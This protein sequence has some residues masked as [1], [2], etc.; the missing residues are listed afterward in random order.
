M[1]NIPKEKSKSLTILVTG[2]GGDI[3]QSVIKCLRDS[4]YELYLIG[5]DIDSYAG[6]QQDVDVFY[7]APYASQTKEYLN[8]ITNVIKKKKCEYIIPTTEQ[9]IEFYDANRTY[10][11]INEI[12]VLINNPFIINIFS[13]KF[14]TVCFLKRHD[15]LYPETYKLSE[16]NNEL[17][18]PVII[19][20]EI[21]SGGK[22][23]HICHNDDELIYFKNMC[24][25]DEIVQEII[26]NPDEEYTIGIFS[27][28]FSVYCI[29]FRRYLD[30]GGRTKVAELIKDDKIDL[31]ARN[32]ARAC[33]LIGSINL[34]VRKTENGFVTFEINPRLSSTVYFRHFFGFRDVEWWLNIYEGYPTEFIPKYNKGIAVRTFDEIFIGLE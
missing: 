14:R 23:I 22:G 29:A 24:N 25:D 17:E 2:I 1:I 8:F 9:E 28:G 11:E 27:D 12:K 32:L 15:F 19:K 31:L 3:G 20:K 7:Q 34:Q 33:K 30:Y 21:G 5:C 18:F 13:N 4:H 26:G 10:F 16:F 6:G